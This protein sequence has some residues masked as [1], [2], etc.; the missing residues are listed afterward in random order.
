MY[1]QEFSKKVDE[2]CGKDGSKVLRMDGTV[3]SGFFLLLTG[4]QEQGLYSTYVARF[5]LVVYSDK[6]LLNS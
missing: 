1:F 2:K 4:S 6:R 5:N 3:C